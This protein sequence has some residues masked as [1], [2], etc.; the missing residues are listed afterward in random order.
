MEGVLYSLLLK[1]ALIRKPKVMV[2]MTKHMKK[3]MMRD[4]SLFSRTTIGAIYNT[5]VKPV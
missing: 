2:A 5:I 3:T 1:N 4:G